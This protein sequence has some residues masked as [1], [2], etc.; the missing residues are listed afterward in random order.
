MLRVYP[1][2]VKIKDF[3]T[4]RTGSPKTLVVFGVLSEGEGYYDRNAMK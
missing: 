3:A 1:S 4:F 2:S